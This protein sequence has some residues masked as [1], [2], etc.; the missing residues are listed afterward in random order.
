MDIIIKDSNGQ[1]IE[2]LTDSTLSPITGQHYWFVVNEYITL[3]STVVIPIST[4]VT[5]SNLDG[6]I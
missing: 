2:N 5:F 1:I 3:P 6:E 4:K